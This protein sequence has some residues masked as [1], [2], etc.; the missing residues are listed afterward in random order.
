MPEGGHY[1]C[2]ITPWLDEDNTLLEQISF[3]KNIDIH[4]PDEVYNAIE[5]F[6]ILESKFLI[7]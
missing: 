1:A 5:A 3:L 4:K 6:E 2:R 7:T